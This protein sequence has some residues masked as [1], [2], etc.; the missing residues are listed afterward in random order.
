MF[1]RDDVLMATSRLASAGFERWAGRGPRTH[2]ALRE[3]LVT[4]WERAETAPKPRRRLLRRAISLALNHLPA[5]DATRVPWLTYSIPRP[6]TGGGDGTVLITGATGF[7]GVHLLSMLLHETD[8]RV[9][10]VVRTPEKLAE[11][12]AEYALTLPHLAERVTFLRGNFNDLTRWLE[13]GHPEWD[14]VAP[15][16]SMVFHLACNTSFTAQ[17]EILRR[18][19]MPGFAALCRFCATNGAAMHLVGSVGRFAVTGEYRTKRGV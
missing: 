10:C 7:V 8:R 9:V 5:V 16:I 1:A 14:A 3:G 13:G 19:W 18:Q 6:R 11:M 4:A 17:Y 2:E 12:A 15:S